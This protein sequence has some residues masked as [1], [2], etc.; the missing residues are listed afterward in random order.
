MPCLICSIAAAM[1]GTALLSPAASTA[2]GRLMS[3]E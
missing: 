3:V 2:D 1:L